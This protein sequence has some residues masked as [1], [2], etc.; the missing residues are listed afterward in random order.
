MPGE[1]NTEP[2]AVAPDAG[3]N[4]AVDSYCLVLLPKVTFASGASTTPAGLPPWG[5]RSALGSV[6]A[7]QYLA[8]SSAARLSLY[9]HIIRSGVVVQI[10]FV[11]PKKKHAVPLGNKIPPGANQ[12]KIVVVVADDRD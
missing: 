9:N 3:V 8:G 5:P 4:V 11:N 7:S 6:V 10:T 12:Q 2:S 1:V